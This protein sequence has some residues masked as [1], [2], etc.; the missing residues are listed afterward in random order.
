MK[1]K[2]RILKIIV[3]I[4]LLLNVIAVSAQNDDPDYY[5]SKIGIQFTQDGKLA[6][7]KDA[8]GNSPITWDFHTKLT[9]EGAE[10]A[11]GHS[12]YGISTEYADLKGGVMKRFGGEAGYEF[13]NLPVPFTA[14]KYS[15]APMVGWGQV[16]RFDERYDS[17][18]FTVEVAFMLTKN[19]DLIILNTY[20]E[21]SDVKAGEYRYNLAF[22]IQLNLDT[23]WR[24]K[25]AEKGTSF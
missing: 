10:R 5:G 17:F 16:Y 4:V 7:M 15:L 12:R 18:E 22:G 1:T 9:L 20:T 6:V 19:L 13:T 8:H 24:K 3:V 23:N 25:Q 11:I 2:V 21:R 14:I